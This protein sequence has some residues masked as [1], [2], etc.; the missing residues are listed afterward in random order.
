MDGSAVCRPRDASPSCQ[1]I[2]LI[3]LLCLVMYWLYSFNRGKSAF[4]TG[5]R[6]ISDYRNSMSFSTVEALI[7]LQ[8]WFRGTALRTPI[9]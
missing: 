9:S 8:D 3:W 7:C 4:S 1:L 6:V 2:G 5:S